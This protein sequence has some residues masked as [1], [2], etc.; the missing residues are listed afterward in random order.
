MKAVVWHGPHDVRVETVDD[1]S[2][3][4]P[5][6]AIVRVTATSICGSDVHLYN[7]FIPRMQQGDI[8]GHEF[9]GIVEEVGPSVRNLQVGDRVV[10]PFAIA[11]GNCEQCQRERYSLCDNSNPD[12]AMLELLYGYG[13]GGLFGYSH[14]FGGYSGGQAEYVR[15]PFAD[16]GPVVVPD[17][18]SDEQV[19]YLSDIFPTGYMAAENCDIKRGDVVAVWGCGPVGQFAIR[20]AFMLGASRV[21]AIDRF[22]E[23]LDLAR[24]SGAETLDH[25]SADVLEALHELTGGRGPDSCIDCVGMEAHGVTPD[26]V[27]DKVKQSVHIELDRAHVLREAIV[28]CGKGG[29]ISIPGVYAGNIDA[30]P[31]GAVFG[32]GLRLRTGQTH[33]HRYI[34]PLLERIDRGEI[35]PSFVVT[36]RGTLDDA[37]QVY[38]NMAKHRDA[39]VKSFLRPTVSV[40]GGID[41]DEVTVP[42]SMLGVL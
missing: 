25:D 37:P 26:A 14:L 42:A 22:D 3:V 29:T 13:A 9:M 16:F 18:L 38:R 30:M 12:A 32:K 11:C 7:G 23:R 27:M 10:V 31:M 1:P 41:R 39:T 17:H 15:V 28:A 40:D 34:R 8:L 35:D 6:D 19:L 4:N 33:M 21:V 24:D 2:I 5:R 20:S 36:H